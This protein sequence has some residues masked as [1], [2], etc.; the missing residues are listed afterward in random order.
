MPNM[1]PLVYVNEKITSKFETP[2]KKK[3]SCWL[4]LKYF[5]P[6]NYMTPTKHGPRSKVKKVI[7][8]DQVEKIPIKTVYTYVQL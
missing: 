2:I 8:A 3:L 7:R 4:L 5:C 1:L 6:A